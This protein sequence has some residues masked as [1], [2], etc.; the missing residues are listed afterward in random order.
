MNKAN[1]TPRQIVEHLDQYIVGQNDAKESSCC[2]TTKSLSK[3][4]Y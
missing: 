2:C 3:I 4:V 1:L